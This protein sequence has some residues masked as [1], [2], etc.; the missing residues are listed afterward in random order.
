MSTQLASPTIAL[1]CRNRKPNK[2]FHIHFYHKKQL[3]VQQRP[4]LATWQAISV[5][6]SHFTPAFYKVEIDTPMLIVLVWQMHTVLIL[7]VYCKYLSPFLI[8]EDRQLETIVSCLFLMFWA[9]GT[10]T[11]PGNSMACCTICPITLFFADDLSST[12]GSSTHISEHFQDCAFL[13]AVLWDFFFQSLTDGFVP[14][15]DPGLMWSLLRYPFALFHLSVFWWFFWIKNKHWVWSDYFIYTVP[16]TKNE[17]TL[18][19][20]SNI[21]I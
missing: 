12:L 13:M 21:C 14:E 1:S 17:I 20:M 7:S 10:V 8:L 4:F 19:T 9:L 16:F 11:G 18:K 2:L 5:C 3:T 15:L 6:P